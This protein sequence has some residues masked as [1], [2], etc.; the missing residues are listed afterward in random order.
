MA[1]LYKQ[2]VIRR[3]QMYD[4]QGLPGVDTFI[5]V[6]EQPICEKRSVQVG[7]MLIAPFLAF[8]M[9]DVAED[10]QTKNALALVQENA[11]VFIPDRDAEEKLVD[12][13]IELLK[14]KDLQ[15][16]L[17]A[18]IGKMAMPNADEVIAK[19]VFKISR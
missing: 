14:D 7:E 2:V 6:Y 9:N 16:K 11:A 18:N 4:M 17:S 3:V 13:A 10:H 5:D 8:G 15:T 12:K 1:W 19:E